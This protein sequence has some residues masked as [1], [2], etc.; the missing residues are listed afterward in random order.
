[1]SR[2]IP[3]FSPEGDAPAGAGL[4]DIDVLDS[5]VPTEEV[6]TPE[7]EDEEEP[8]QP[9]EPEPEE[10][11]SDEEDEPEQPEAE[12]EEELVTEDGTLTIKNI[13]KKYPAFFKEFPEVRR[14]FFLA[15]QFQQV[16]ASP[17][18]AGNAKAVAD[19]F[20][21][22]EQ[23]LL[24]GS[25]KEI[26]QSLRESGDPDA[27]AK[28]VKNFLPTLQETDRNLYFDVT[29][30]VIQTVLY[31]AIRTAQTQGNKN[32]Q[33]A[34]KWINHFVFGDADVKQPEQQRL[35]NKLDPE[36]QQFL[37]EKAQWEAGR[38]GQ[39]Y[40][41]VANEIFND[42]SKRIVKNLDPK[43]ELGEY[44]RKK[45][46][47][48]VIREIG[49][50]LQNNPQHIRQMDSLWD[51]HRK[52]G[53][54]RNGRTRIKDTFLAR[55]L[56]LAPQVTAQLRSEAL[57]RRAKSAQGKTTRPKGQASNTRRSDK[58]EFKNTA[59]MTDAQVLDKILGD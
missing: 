43:E 55:A 32:L 45:L 53:L 49:N 11:D 15:N 22:F 47:G 46:L 48:D 23:K 50:R 27:Q 40:S 3:I 52:T 57:G 30:P 33:E 51:K 10:E 36:R 21:F 42:L 38:F 17:E 8:E 26:L 35:E 18:D 4:S 13:L 6:E 41:E 59:R 16:F 39:E 7:T 19:T 56:Q 31:A 1:M 5:M 12:P 54:P 20:D 9:S 14:N 2:V 34:A 44:T 24:S 28:F 58:S 29:A 25:S 37:Q